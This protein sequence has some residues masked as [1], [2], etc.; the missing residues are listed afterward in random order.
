MLVQI[1]GAAALFF[2]IGVVFCLSVI[3]YAG[4]CKKT[5]RMKVD[6][7]N[8]GNLVTFFILAWPYVLWSIIT[9]GF[10]DE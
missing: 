7:N 6:H 3:L 1:L 10:T 8:M 2:I 9:T 5:L 4:K